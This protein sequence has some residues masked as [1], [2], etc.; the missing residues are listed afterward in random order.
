MKSVN[1]FIVSIAFL[2]AAYVTALRFALPLS[3]L[4]V[5]VVGVFLTICFSRI[6]LRIKELIKASEAALKPLQ[7]QLAKRSGID[8]FKLFE[9]VEKGKTPLTRYSQVILALHFTAIVM[10]VFG[11]IHAYFLWKVP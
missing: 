6:E 4:G 8:N 11:A 3:A 7:E 9:L 1:F 10:F 5:A 2:T